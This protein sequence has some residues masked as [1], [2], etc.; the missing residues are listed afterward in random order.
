MAQ[1]IVRNLDDPLKRCLQQRT[2]L[3]GRSMEAEVREI[4]Q[5]AVIQGSA[6]PTV[7]GTRIAN[8]FK[9]N[10]LD[11]PIDE[12]RGWSVQISDFQS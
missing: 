3:H 5:A 10:G 6:L 7:L 9:G 11:A 8:R 1:L 12:K 4:L 2:K